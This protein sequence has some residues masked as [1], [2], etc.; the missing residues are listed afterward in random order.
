VQVLL[1]QSR[2]LREYAL[3]AWDTHEL[4]TRAALEAHT[5]IRNI[6]GKVDV[7]LSQARSGG[8]PLERVL[9]LRQEIAEIERE[10]VGRL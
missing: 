1:Y 2:E 4:R 10:M 7:I 6:L 3:R 8:R 9:A 5:K